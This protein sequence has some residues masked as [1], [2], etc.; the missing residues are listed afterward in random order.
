MSKINSFLQKRKMPNCQY[1]IYMVVIAYVLSFV[2]LVLGSDSF[3]SINSRAAGISKESFE[4]TQ[5]S[6]NDRSQVVGLN[7]F[8]TSIYHSIAFD[9]DLIINEYDNTQDSQITQIDMEQVQ[10]V[11]SNTNWLLGFGLDTEQYDVIMERMAELKTIDPVEQ[12]ENTSNSIESNSIE[13]FSLKAEVKAE[14]DAAKKSVTKFSKEDVEI[15]ERI[16]EAEAS[17]EDIVGKVLVANVVL[18][19]LDD[20]DFPDTVK[21]VVFQKV[22]GVYQFSPIG[23]KRYWSVKVSKETKEAVQQAI[24]GEDYSHGALYFMARKM[25]KSSNAKWFD[26]NLNWLFR[27]GGHEFYN[28]K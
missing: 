11:S 28:N 15:I 14:M 10:T 2:L 3:Y 4:A 27:H 17:G 16:V 1:G 25:T 20:K 9:T 21:E 6:D 8:A 13:S 18:N 23:D 22:K 7:D 26:R 24:Q 5:Y 19:R 12:A